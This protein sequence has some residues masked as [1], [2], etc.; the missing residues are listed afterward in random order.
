MSTHKP[1]PLDIT[2]DFPCERRAQRAVP[3]AEWLKPSALWLKFEFRL[4]ELFTL[5]SREQ[6]NFRVA[7]KVFD[8]CGNF[9]RMF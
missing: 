2:N 8:G 1:K 3:S 9:P 5:G 7:E 6:K 4:T